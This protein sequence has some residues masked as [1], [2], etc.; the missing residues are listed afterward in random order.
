MTNIALVFP[1]QG[2]QSVGMGKDLYDKYEVCKNIFDK[3]DKI[4]NLPLT[5]FCFNG[6]EELL[7][8]TQNT[9]PSIVT[10]S[11]ACF[12][13][14]E[15][16]NISYKAIAG[17]SVG[18]Y[19]ALAA[20]KTLSFE[21]VLLLVRKRGELMSVS[22]DKKSAMAAI[23]GLDIKQVELICL[24][25]SH[26]GAVVLANVNSPEQ[27][28]ISGE[29]LAVDEAI[30]L[31]FASGAKRVKKLSVAG[32]FH[33][34]LMQNAKEKL[35]EEIDKY[36]FKN[37][38]V[39]IVCNVSAE[40]VN[41]LEKIKDCMK[42]QITSKVL[43]VDIINNMMKNGIDTFIEIGPGKVLSGLIKKI[44]KET[45]TFNLYDEPSFLKLKEGIKEMN[46]V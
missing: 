9:Q 10:M 42:E 3:A 7:I 2:S 26:L 27:V 28:V 41:S 19:T 40:Y 24:E 38:E 4:L 30:N 31:S 20:S 44:S 45:K 14:F 34:P 43:W 12:K 17:H 16:L 11:Y 36:N 13:L 32:A 33:S 22:S 23:V 8:Q 1:G 39:P 29:D 35:G 21:E 15:T 6:P 5:D 46:S 37:L 25:A 18:E